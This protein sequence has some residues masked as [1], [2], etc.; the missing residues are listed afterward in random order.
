MTCDQN[1]NGARNALFLACGNDNNGNG[2]CNID[3]FDRST[4]YK[5]I[6]KLNFYLKFNHLA[7]FEIL[8]RKSKYFM[9]S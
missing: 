1:C 5:N 2:R 3:K 9:K 8:Y 4:A 6:S 7:I